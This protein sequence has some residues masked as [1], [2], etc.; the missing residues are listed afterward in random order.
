VP[1]RLYFNKR[2]IA[3]CELGLA[4]GKK[5]RD[6]RQTQKD[7]DWQRQKSRVLQSRDL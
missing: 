2:G 6:K 5:Q 3:K 1:V 4:K 7:R